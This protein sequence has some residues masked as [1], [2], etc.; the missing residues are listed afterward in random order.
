MFKPISSLSSSRSSKQ[1]AAE[2]NLCP[3][4][5]QVCG[6]RSETAFALISVIGMGVFAIAI[7]FGLFPLV[8]N[9]IQNE[10][11]AR[12]IGELRT[13]AESGVDYAVSQL[14]QSAAN[15]L[16][17]PIDPGAALSKV[18]ALPALYQTNPNIAVQIQVRRLSSSD[19]TNVK[20]FSSLYHSD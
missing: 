10:S 9:A 8:L 4:K 12:Y 14:N 17:C 19:W 2:R 1:T 11:G 5:L 15:Q 13:A 16:P 18:S 20:S 7:M 3:G 6:R